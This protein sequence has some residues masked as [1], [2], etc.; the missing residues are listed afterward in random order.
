M[1]DEVKRRID[2][3]APG[4]GF[5]FCPVHNIQ[6]DVPTENLEAMWETMLDYGKY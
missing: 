2:D 1:R 3:L 5:L 6:M 4:G